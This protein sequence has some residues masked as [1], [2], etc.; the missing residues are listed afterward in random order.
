MGYVAFSDLN[1]MLDEHLSDTAVFD[2][3]L[4]NYLKVVQHG[5]TYWANG[6]E[7][8]KL[9]TPWGKSTTL[10]K[11]YYRLRALRDKRDGQAPMLTS[12]LVPLPQF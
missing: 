4:F 8:K 1:N 3:A 9:R 11:T 5:L 10:L 7:Q 2:G 12:L 6:F